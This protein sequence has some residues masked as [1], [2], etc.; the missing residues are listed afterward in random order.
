VIDSTEENKSRIEYH[1]VLHEY[2][3]IFLE[4]IPILPP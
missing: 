4:E 2:K 3:D 1:I